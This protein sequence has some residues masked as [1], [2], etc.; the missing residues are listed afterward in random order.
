M[1]S[2]KLYAFT[3]NGYLI[4]SSASSG[5]IESFKKISSEISSD[6]IINNGKLYIVAENSKIIGLN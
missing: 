6:P 3:K 5:K 2:G 1:G 4:I